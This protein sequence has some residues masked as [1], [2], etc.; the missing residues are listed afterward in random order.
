MITNYYLMFSPLCIQS[1]I[2]CYYIIL[3][4]KSCPK[5][6]INKPS[7][8]T[9]TISMYWY[10]WC[11]QLFSTS[12]Y[13]RFQCSSSICHKIYSICSHSSSSLPSSSSGNTSCIHSW[14][15]SRICICIWS[16]HTKTC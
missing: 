13:L 9:K 16:Y 3:N 12:N 2:W 7:R 8:K 4:I 6:T 1:Q 11:I 5:I 14:I 15:I 10:N